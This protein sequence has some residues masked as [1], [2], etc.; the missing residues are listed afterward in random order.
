MKTAWEKYNG[1]KMRV[2]TFKMLYIE[3]GYK[4]IKR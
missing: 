1:K 4:I 2:L 3:K